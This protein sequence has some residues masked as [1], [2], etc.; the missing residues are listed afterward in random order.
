MIKKYL[1]Y[2]LRKLGLA[3]VS[4]HLRYQ[5]MRLIN[6]KENNTFKKI[7]PLVSLPPDYLMYESFQ[8]NYHKYYAGGHEDAQWII[9]LAKPYSKLLGIKILDWGCGP[10]RILRHFPS[11]LRAENEYY[12]TDYNP[13]TIHWCQQ[14]ISGI[15]FSLNNLYPPLPYPDQSFSF[16]YGVSV[17]THL[18]KEGQKLWSDELYRITTHDGIVILTTHGDA[19]IEKLTPQEAMTY[20]NQDLIS[21]RYGKEGHR[22]YGT[23]HPPS[24]I[25]NIFEAA[26]F[27]ITQHIQGS[28]INENYI[29]QDVWILRK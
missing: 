22:T 19:F 8:M 23:F 27:K 12:G 28:K 9:S 6:Q 21:R 14:N 2:T 24:F 13:A 18:S 29:S 1:A 20:Q 26:G 15:T 3:G 7:N 17:L 5:L 25:R 10:A 16:I 11:L 4:D